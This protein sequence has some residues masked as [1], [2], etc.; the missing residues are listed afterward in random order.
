MYKVRRLKDAASEYA[1]RSLPALG[2]SSPFVAELD[3]GADARPASL[4]LEPSI[5]SPPASPPAS[6]P[7]SKHK[8][9]GVLCV[10]F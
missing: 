1:E 2:S 8:Y 10:S 7:P 6:P 3:R 5:D 9:L 4:D